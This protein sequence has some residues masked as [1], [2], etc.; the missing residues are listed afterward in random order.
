MKNIFTNRR[1][2]DS[3]N[4]IENLTTYPRDYFVENNN[5]SDDDPILFI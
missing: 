1:I 3:E 2:T 4:S 5:G